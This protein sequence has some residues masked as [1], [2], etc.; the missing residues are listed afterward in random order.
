MNENTPVRKRPGS[1][2]SLPQG[3]PGS[4]SSNDDIEDLGGEPLGDAFTPTPPVVSSGGWAGGVDGGIVRAGFSRAD[5]IE[6]DGLVYRDETP[7]DPIPA[8]EMD[9]PEVL[10]RLFG[11]NW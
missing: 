7:G 1:G 6:Q 10:S 5:K 3:M 11:V 4:G 2:P 9:N 8:Y